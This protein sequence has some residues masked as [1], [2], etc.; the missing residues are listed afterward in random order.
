VAEA[1][2]QHVIATMPYQSGEER[3]VNGTELPLHHYV[4]AKPLSLY[5]EAVRTLRTAIEMS[6]VDSPPRIVMVTSS[7]PAEGKS[8]ISLSLAAATQKAGKS[9]I[10]IDL[11]LR[12]PV[13]GTRMGVSPEQ[14]IVDYLL[15]NADLRS[16][17]QIDPVSGV[18]FIPCVS[19]SIANAPDLLASERLAST[20]R[21]LAKH[22]D[23]VVLD[24]APVM[25][26]SDARRLAQLVDKIVYV[27]EWNKTPRESVTAAFAELAEASGKMAGIVFSKADMARFGEYNYQARGYYYRKYSYYRSGYGSAASLESGDKSKLVRFTRK[28]TDRDAA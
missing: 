1:T 18:H 12:R 14:G 24:S 13:I 20:I 3:A 4:I 2:G 15:G 23:L 10:I 19:S 27:V 6:N 16:V 5:A 26:A 7:V 25:A 11:D 9:T 8:S 21:Q 17:I 28:N 22:Y